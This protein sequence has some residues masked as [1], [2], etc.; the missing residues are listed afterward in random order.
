MKYSIM[1]ILFIIQF[2][3]VYPKALLEVSFSFYENENDVITL[4]TGLDTTA[5]NSIDKNLDEY[6][7]PP[8]PPLGSFDIRFNLKGTNGILNDY[9]HIG[10]SDPSTITEEYYVS[11]QLSGESDEL[12]INYDITD[13]QEFSIVDQ[14]GS[15]LTDVMKSGRGIIEIPASINNFIIKVTYKNP[16]K[17]TG[18][19]INNPDKPGV[20]SLGQNYPNPFNPATRI[21]YDLPEKSFVNVSIYNLLGER[22]AELVNG[23]M[24]AGYHEVEFSAGS[25]GNAGS[26]SSGVY[27][28]RIVTEKEHSVKKMVF[29][30]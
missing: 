9:R 20:F 10:I 17:L 18:L 19:E 12:K 26:L 7:M 22:V 5:T 24:E 23:E 27:I 30:K 14:T 13:A 21:K 8:L 15:L 29:L 25:S 3:P 4:K 11:A 16:L 1:F 2:N 28:Y 6:E